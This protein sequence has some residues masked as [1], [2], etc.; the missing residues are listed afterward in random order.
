MGI[1]LAWLG[2]A[3]EVVG[4][5]GGKRF[6]VS[7]SGTLAIL[8]GAMGWW[9][10]ATVSHYAEIA[11]GYVFAQGALDKLTGGATSST[12]ST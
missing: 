9:D 12:G 11:I 4:K 7:F 3:H 2:K 6:L 1:V 8:G 10:E 5:L